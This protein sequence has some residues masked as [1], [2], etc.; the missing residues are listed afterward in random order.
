MLGKKAVNLMKDLTEAGLV[1]SVRRGL[2]K[3]N[4]IY[5]KDFGTALESDENGEKIQKEYVPAGYFVYRFKDKDEKVIYIGKTRLE[6]SKRFKGHTHL[7]DECYKKV[8]KVEYL[9]FYSK[10]DMD[11]AE[12]YFIS[13][14]KPDYNIEHIDEQASMDIPGLNSLCDSDWTKYNIKKELIKTAPAS[15]ATKVQKL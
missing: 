10:T 13:K 9:V 7:P 8:K 1:E 12:Q 11:I 15:T 14:A 5:V 6:L 3:P 2:G 4:I